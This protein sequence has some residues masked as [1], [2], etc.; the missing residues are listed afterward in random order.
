VRP[1]LTV[2]C[3]RLVKF[4]QR[5]CATYSTCLL[6]WI[7]GPVRI[8]L[9]SYSI[10][11]SRIDVQ[12]SLLEVPVGFSVA[13]SCVLANRVVFNV[14]EV[15]RDMGR[16]KNTSQQAMG[17]QQATW[18]SFCSPGCLTQFEMDQLRSMR[19]ELDGAD[20]EDDSVDLPFVVL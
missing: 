14:R 7:I 8:L 18:A 1:R 20:L 4:L 15:N 17:K 6:V 3:Q 9:L 5:I 13:M 2:A 12:T 19:V 11:N 10:Y 16:S